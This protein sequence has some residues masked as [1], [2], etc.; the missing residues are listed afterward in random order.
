M[1]GHQR[2]ES[3]LQLPPNDR[4]CEDVQAGALER[5]AAQI[6]RVLFLLQPT[7]HLVRAFRTELLILLQLSNVLLHV[8]HLLRALFFAHHREARGLERTK[9]TC[10]DFRSPDD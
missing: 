6:R 8:R 4:R 5:M 9:A 3:R 10:L 1:L 2:K 7:K